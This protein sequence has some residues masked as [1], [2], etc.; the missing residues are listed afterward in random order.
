MAILAN[1]AANLQKLLDIAG[2]V[3]LTWGI[4]FNHKKSASIVL[5][6]PPQAT[7]LF[8]TKFTIGD[9]SIPPAVEYIYLG[10]NVAQTD[11]EDGLYNSGLARRRNAARAG[12]RQLQDRLPPKLHR[13]KEKLMGLYLERV[14]PLM[15]Y[16][17]PALDLSELQITKMDSAEAYICSSLGLQRPRNPF[18]QRWTMARR[19]FVVK[20]LGAPEGT[21]RRDAAACLPASALAKIM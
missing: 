14:A 4:P 8:D 18:S 20:M 19:N 17:T 2:S 9:T 7:Q 3:A 10:F 21:W 12:A 5:S 16:A 1:S 6:R 15:D 13:D 11:D